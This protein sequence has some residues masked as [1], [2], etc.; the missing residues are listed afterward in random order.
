[1]ESFL[2]VPSEILKI[3]SVK[4]AKEGISLQDGTLLLVLKD[5]FLLLNV[6]TSISSFFPH[7]YFVEESNGSQIASYHPTADSKGSSIVDCIYLSSHDAFLVI[8]SNSTIVTVPKNATNH[9]EYITT[10]CPI[11]PLKIHQIILSGQFYLLCEG[12]WCCRLRFENGVLANPI[13]AL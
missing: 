4:I 5:Q 8:L 2:E 1:M 10:P 7:R 13:P 3:E 9:S 6:R 12:G 11:Q